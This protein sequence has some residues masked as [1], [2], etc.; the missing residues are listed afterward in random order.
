MVSRI[1]FCRANTGCDGTCD[2]VLSLV[3]AAKTAN[4]VSDMRRNSYRR[5]MALYYCFLGISEMTFLDL[6]H[7]KL[8][9]DYHIG[10]MICVRDLMQSGYCYELVA[11]IGEDFD[12]GFCPDLS[13]KEMLVLGVFEGKYL[14][15]CTGEL[16][17]E[18]YETA[19]KKGKLSLCADESVN[20]FGVKS[21]QSLSV[22]RE[23]GWILPDD[24]DVRGWFQWYCR[25]YLGRRDEILDMRQIKRWRAFSR[26]RGQILKH[27]VRGD[28]TCRPKQRQALLQW[29]YDPFL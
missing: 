8:V 14:N 25:Y 12:S 20:Y 1:F 17:R 24:P 5:Y 26:H 4:G 3:S 28:L 19:L 7:S 2:D 11:P 21:R 29:A 15:D 27:C 16:P 13:P 22:W 6:S 18:W 10:Q 9:S 23:K